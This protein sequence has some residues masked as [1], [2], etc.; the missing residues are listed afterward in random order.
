MAQERIL[1]V[2]DDPRVRDEMTS[3]CP[4][5][6]EVSLR[7]DAR[8]A[9]ESMEKRRPSVVVVDMQTGSAGG[10][11]LCKDMSQSD[12]LRDVPVVILLERTQDAWLARQAGATLYRVKPIGAHELFLDALELLPQ[13]A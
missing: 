7:H 9:W 10:Y 6:V 12:R 1:V 13:G 5:G 4:S 11:G 3:A 2:S 8:D